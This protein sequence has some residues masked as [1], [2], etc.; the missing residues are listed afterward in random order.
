MCQC[1]V[2]GTNVLT[3][4]YLMVGIILHDIFRKLG[5]FDDSTD[6][7]SCLVFW[8]AVLV[9]GTVSCYLVN[10]RLPHSARP[11]RP[12]EGLKEKMSITIKYI[13]P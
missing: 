10:V 1:L 2:S 4:V 13:P 5:K 8:F 3:K 6:L 12:L 11:S 9:T 7:T